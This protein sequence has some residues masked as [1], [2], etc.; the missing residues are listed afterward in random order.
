MVNVGKKLSIAFYWHMHQP[1]YQL[2]PDSDYL[3]PW[4]RL[5][6][7]KDYLDMLLVTKSFNGLR[8]NFNI[9]PALI[10]AIINYGEKDFHDIHSRLSIT[11]ISELTPDDKEFILNNFFDANYTTMLEPHQSYNELYKKRFSGES[12][13]IESFSSQEYSDI[14]MWHNL[15]WIDPIYKDL[16]PEFKKLLKKEKNY[17][18]EDRI[19][20]IELHRK[21]IRMIIPTYKELWRQNKIEITTSPYYHPILPIL[22]DAKSSQKRLSAE[23]SSLYTMDFKEDAKIQTQNALDRIEEV[24][25]QRP[26]G[27]W[28]PELGISAPELELFKELG[29]QW[30]ISDEGILAN[31]LNQEFRGR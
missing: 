9:V 24:F 31:S 3:M 6:S 1:V 12:I 2:N 28:P 29:V 16:F 18:L 10:D 20:I 27:I 21:I 26:K 8:L 14:M 13:N 5:H 30:T 4:V 23:D 22:L 19:E 11:D 25:G 15:V 7:V 17:T